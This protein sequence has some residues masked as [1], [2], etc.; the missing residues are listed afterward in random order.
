MLPL[1]KTLTIIIH[2]ILQTLAR[3]NEYIYIVRVLIAVKLKGIVQ[4]YVIS[5]A[6][7]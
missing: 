7:E 1:K 2:I 4:G 5:L 6:I 3:A